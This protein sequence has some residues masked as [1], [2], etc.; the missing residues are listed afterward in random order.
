MPNCK[1]EANDREAPVVKAP[2]PF[3][4]AGSQ[5]AAHLVYVLSHPLPQAFQIHFP[6]ERARASPREKS[7]GSPLP[8]RVP[9]RSSVTVSQARAEGHR[10]VLPTL[11]HVR[12][13]TTLAPHQRVPMGAAAIR[14]PLFLWRNVHN[15]SF[16][17]PE[18]PALRMAFRTPRW[19]VR[20]L[21]INGLNM[22][23]KEQ[24][25]YI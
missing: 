4:A 13:L 5:E 14:F 9:C 7:A 15:C 3:Y 16:S 25:S 22:T 23:I 2:C 18:T 10:A 17:L 12:H 19:L 11:R 1:H 8:E 20:F 6:A 21:A 24:T